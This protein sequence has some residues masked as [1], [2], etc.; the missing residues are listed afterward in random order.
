MYIGDFEKVA[1]WDSQA[2]KGCKRF[3][4]RVWSLSDCV[5][6]GDD[7]RKELES[8][9]HKTVKK[10]TEDFEKL[11]FN[12]AI[13]QMMI[14]VNAVYK[15]GKCPRAYAEGLIKMLSCICPHI[16]EELWSILGHEGTIAYEPWPVHDEAKTVDDCLEMPVQI[17][18]KVKEKLNVSISL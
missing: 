3:L 13:S 10:V 17:N 6:D 8:E 7:Y 1:S 4:D 2:V 15:E 18:G 12:T 9:F 14:F 16:G 11:A 5:I